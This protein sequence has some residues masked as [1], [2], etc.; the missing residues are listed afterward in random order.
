MIGANNLCLTATGEKSFYRIVDDPTFNLGRDAPAHLILNELTKRMRVPRFGDYLKRYIHRTYGISE[1][2]GSYS[3]EC[4]IKLIEKNFKSRKTPSSFENSSTS[5][6]NAA[7]NWLTR[8]SVSRK[9]VFLLGFGLKMPVDEVNTLLTKALYEQSINPKDP[10]EV[11]CWYC[12]TNS[13]SYSTYERLWRKYC[14]LSPDTS[15]DNFFTASTASI[16]YSMYA[17]INEET[18]FAYIAT[19]KATKDISIFSRTAKEKFDTLYH[20]IQVIIGNDKDI[21]PNEVTPFDIEEY[22]YFGIPKNTDGNLLKENMSDL[23]DIFTGKRLS[24][25]RIGQLISGKTEVIRS[26]IITLNFVIHANRDGIL[27]QTLYYDFCKDT[28]NILEDCSMQGLII[29]NPYDN[30][31]MACTLSRNPIETYWD[32]WAASYGLEEPSHL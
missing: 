11:I 10:F 28:D 1:K 20:E 5:I 18:L 32:V 24:R 13:L 23:K 3:L 27:S 19:L 2:H 31:V 16:R 30:F 6:K 22:I 21:P 9:T 29:Q 26:D 7:K 12:F 14:K 25:Q 15:S 17:I 4:Y 8:K